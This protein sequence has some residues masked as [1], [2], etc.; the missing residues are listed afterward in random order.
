M[1][2]AREDSNFQN[3]NL[4]KVAALPICLRAVKLVFL[5]QIQKAPEITPGLKTKA[6]ENQP[7]GS[8]WFY[9]NAHVYPIHAA[10]RGRKRSDRDKVCAKVFIVLFI[11]EGETSVNNYF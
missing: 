8:E 3:H 1:W 10:R 4:L 5:L 6:S 9:L 2:S 7:R 11:Q